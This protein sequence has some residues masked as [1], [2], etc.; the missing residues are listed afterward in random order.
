MES[1]LP[2]ELK[3]AGREHF[4]PV[5]A[6]RYDQKMD[7]ESE[8]ELALLAERGIGESSTV[9]DLGAGTGQFV[10]TASAAVRRVT[11]VDVSAIMLERLREKVRRARIQ[12][13]DCVL[14]GFLT[15]AH[16]GEPVDLVYTRF[17][18]HH[19]SD[20]WQAIALSR[21]AAILRAGGILRLWDVV[22][23]FEPQ[24]ATSRLEDWISKMA[25]SD[26]EHSWTR[27]ELEEHVRDENSTFT[28][29]LEPMIERAGF[30]IESADYSEDGVFARYVCVKL[31]TTGG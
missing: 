11:A 15:Y 30:A 18:L 3:Y 29:L 25:S 5:H 27:A 28:W 6:A 22:Y 20:F 4:D 19:L 24:E 10:M 8:D 1:W 21:M 16:E 7:A 17:A 26:V 12:N 9:V 14:A 23:S 31:P 13:V 2:D